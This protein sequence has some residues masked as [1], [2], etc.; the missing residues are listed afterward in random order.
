VADL[1]GN[2]EGGREPIVLDNGTGRANGTHSA[3]LGK[4]QGVTALLAR[5]MTEV[6]P[7]DGRKYKLMARRR[8]LKLCNGGEGLLHTRPSLKTRSSTEFLDLAV[9]N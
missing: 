1:V 2:G 6:F 5:I 4:S 3:E 7:A 8:L 9:F